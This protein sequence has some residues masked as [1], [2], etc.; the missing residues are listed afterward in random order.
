MRSDQRPEVGEVV[1]LRPTTKTAGAACRAYLD[2][3]VVSYDRWPL[4]EVAIDKKGFPP[5]VVVHADD[6]GIHPAKDKPTGDMAG[7]GPA[8]LKRPKPSLRPHKPID[9]PPGWEEPTLF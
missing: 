6:C 3:R 4:V 1:H 9:L 7:G 5:R 8:D 2:A